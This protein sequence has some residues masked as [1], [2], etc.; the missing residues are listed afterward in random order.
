MKWDPNETVTLHVNVTAKDMDGVTYRWTK[1]DSENGTI[2]VKDVTGDTYEVTIN[3]ATDINCYVT[4]KYG[5]P[6][7]AW[8]SIRVRNNLRAWPEGEDEDSSN[9][10]VAAAPNE[11]VTMKVMTSATDVSS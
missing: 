4:D 9:K 11:P 10:S 7:E 5:N 3:K 8:F 6:D 1:H 2:D